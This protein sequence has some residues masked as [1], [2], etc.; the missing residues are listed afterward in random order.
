MKKSAKY[1]GRKG[2][3][4]SDFGVGEFVVLC[5]VVIQ[6]TREK[7]AAGDPKNSRPTLSGYRRLI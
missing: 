5:Y 3:I 7:K 2:L 4:A 1:V 6:G